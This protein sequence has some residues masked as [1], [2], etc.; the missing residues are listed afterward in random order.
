[1]TSTTLSSGQVL[2]AGYGVL[3]TTASSVTLNAYTG[4]YNIGVKLTLA[5]ATK[6]FQ[7][8]LQVYVANSAIASSTP[9]SELRSDC[10]I[11]E[12]KPSDRPNTA[13]ILHTPLLPRKGDTVYI[14]Y[15]VPTDLVGCTVDAVCYEIN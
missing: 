14:W 5:S 9:S 2:A 7:T 13:R 3:P 4:S 15:E 10:F 6:M 12:V 11:L 8:V 1:M